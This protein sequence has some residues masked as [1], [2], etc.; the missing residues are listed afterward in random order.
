MN[1]HINFLTEEYVK[2]IAENFNKKVQVINATQF[3]LRFLQDF[4]I[5]PQST[6]ESD[7]LQNSQE[8][9]IYIGYVT[10]SSSTL[11]KT[12]VLGGGSPYTARAFGRLNFHHN[13]SQSFKHDIFPP[14]V[15]DAQKITANYHNDLQVLFL[16]FSNITFSRGILVKHG[17][18]SEIEGNPIYFDTTELFARISLQFTG[19]RLVLE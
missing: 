15:D 2:Q 5:T 1:K 11:S 12:G 13:F 14:T 4:E 17:T 9:V 6:V 19:Y 18:N 10:I 8:G 3:N 7:L 16:S